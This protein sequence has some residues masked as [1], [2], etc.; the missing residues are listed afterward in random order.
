MPRYLPA[1]RELVYASGVAEIAG[2]VGV[3][4]PRTRRAGGLV[5]DRHAG[6]DLPRQRRDGR[7]RRALQAVSPGRAVGA[8][9]APGR[10]DRLGVADRGAL[11]G[12]RRG[13]AGPRPALR[14]RRHPARPAQRPR[15][16]APGARGRARRGHDRAVSGPAPTWQ[17]RELAI[18]AHLASGRRAGRGAERPSS[19]PARTSTTAACSASGRYVEVRRRAGRPGRGGRGPARSA[20]RRCGDFRRLAPGALGRDRGRGPAGPARRRGVDRRRRRRISCSSAS[21]SCT[22]RS[23][24]CA[25]RS[26]RCTATRTSTTC[27]TARRPAVERL[28]GHVP[29]PARLGRGLPDRHGRDGGERAEA[30]LAAS[31]IAL[32]PG[33][34]ALWVEARSLQ[35][36]VW[37]ALP[38]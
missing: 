28:G 5:A 27:S 24:P 13:G 25:R 29:R 26:G 15:P 17:R 16:P 32:D 4:H 7:A 34:L 35:V 30:A 19:R 37:R 11:R 33:E 3:L 36:A 9:P 6:R 20:T 23:A 18:A 10:A 38:G 1:H 2:G 22:R 21:T 12:C 31:G 8:A 14:R